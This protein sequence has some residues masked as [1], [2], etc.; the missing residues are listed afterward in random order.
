MYSR[1]VLGRHLEYSMYMSVIMVIVGTDH[2]WPHFGANTLSQANWYT[3]DHPWTWPFSPL[4]SQWITHS[5]PIKATQVWSARCE[6]V[7]QFMSYTC[8]CGAR[9]EKDWAE[10]IMALFPSALF[11]TSWSLVIWGP[12]YVILDILMHN[13]YHKIYTAV[14]SCDLVCCG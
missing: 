6:F 12:I 3:V 10:C 2:E 9:I 7:T 4:Y 11:H 1:D 8:H 5:S 13:I 14:E